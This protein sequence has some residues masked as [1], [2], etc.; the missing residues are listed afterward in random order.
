MNG[1]VAG[2]KGEEEPGG[3]VAIE[4]TLRPQVVPCEGL[5]GLVVA[6]NQE[7]LEGHVDEE[8]DTAAGEVGDEQMLALVDEISL[9]VASHRLV[10]IPSLEEEEAH[11]EIGPL[12]DFPPPLIVGMATETHDMERHHADNADTAQEIEGMISLF[13]GYKDTEKKHRLGN[14]LRKILSFF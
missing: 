12:H 10:E 9:A 8:S 4:R 3:I 1:N 5:Y 6:M 13:H 11:E 7:G 14:I 2:P